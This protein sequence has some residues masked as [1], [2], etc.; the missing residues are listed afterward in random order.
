MAVFGHITENAMAELLSNPRLEAALRIQAR[1]ASR[2]PP[3]K[4]PLAGKPQKW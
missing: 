2:P 3:Q 4:K 1:L